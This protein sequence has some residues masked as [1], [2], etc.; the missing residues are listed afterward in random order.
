MFPVY[1]HPDQA[2]F[3]PMYEWALGKKIKHPETTRRVESIW[4]A[5]E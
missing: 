1:F 3:R 5:L 4:R 2:S